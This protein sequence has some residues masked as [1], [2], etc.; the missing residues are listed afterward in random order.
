MSFLPR[1]LSRDELI[2]RHG[3][4]YKWMALIIVGLGSVAAVLA[5]TSFSVAVP[6]LGRAFGIGQERVQW[7][8]TGFMAALTVAML[9]TPWLLDHIGFRRLFLGELGMLVG[10]SVAGALGSLAPRRP[11][12]IPPIRRPSCCWRRHSGWRWWRRRG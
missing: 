7:A 12:S 10:T 5:T 1:A 6:A 11:A 4:R 9:P 8:I 2:Q 3:E